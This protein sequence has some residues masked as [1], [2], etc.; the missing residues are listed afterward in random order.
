MVVMALLRQGG[1]GRGEVGARFQE[2]VWLCLGS[3]AFAKRK[4]SL[5][6]RDKPH[7]PLLVANYRRLNCSV[8]FNA[9]IARALVISRK[10]EL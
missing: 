1:L 2:A 4:D 10:G 5:P 7:A 6:L 8:H 9:G 3:A